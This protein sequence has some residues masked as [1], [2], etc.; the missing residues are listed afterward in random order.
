MLS[1]RADAEDPGLW[2]LNVLKDLIGG[3]VGVLSPKVASIPN[4]HLIIT[5][6]N[7][8]WTIGFS[9]NNKHEPAGFSELGSQNPR[10]CLM[11]YSR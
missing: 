1:S 5:D 11:Q 3:D 6:V 4:L 2:V 8:D 7:V 10:N 9:F